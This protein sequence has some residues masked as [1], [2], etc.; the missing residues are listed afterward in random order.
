LAERGVTTGAQRIAGTTLKEFI[1]NPPAGYRVE[2]VYKAAQEPSYR[3]ARSFTLQMLDCSSKI[4][5]D[6]PIEQ[7]PDDVF[8]HFES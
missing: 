1:L 8:V 5:N 3:Y 6:E 2:P 4:L 7:R